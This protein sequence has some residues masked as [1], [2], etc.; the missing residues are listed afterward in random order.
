MGSPVFPIVA[1]LFMEF[2]EQKAIAMA[3]ITCAPRFWKRYVDAILAIIRKGQVDNLT[4][5]LNQADETGSMKKI[6]KEKSISGHSDV[7]KE[8]ATVK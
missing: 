6:K 7:K 2:L 8:D 5:H 4:K 3:P 1:N